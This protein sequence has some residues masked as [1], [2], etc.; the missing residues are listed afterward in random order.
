M[1]KR[2]KRKRQRS[3]EHDGDAWT[4]FGFSIERKTSFTSLAAFILSVLSLIYL[5]YDKLFG[6]EIAFGIRSISVVEHKESSSEPFVDLLLE[7]Y[8][9]NTS[10]R[11]QKAVLRNVTI[12]VSIGK[13]HHSFRPYYFVESTDERGW[14]KFTYSVGASSTLY[15]RQLSSFYPKSL[16]PFT[17]HL[18]EIEL[19]NDFQNSNLP[20]VKLEQV[21]SELKSEPTARF[22]VTFNIEGEGWLP[23]AYHL[24]TGQSRVECTT[25]F[26]PGSHKLQKLTSD[27]WVTPELECEARNLTYWFTHLT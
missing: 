7:L 2:R 26:R 16:A 25:D 24:L 11:S 10:D 13:K 12:D 9:V 20:G 19:G 8:M 4:A 17:D 1:A 14:E 3:A 21:I 22:E 23:R 27:R 18:V 15:I 5:V 6:A